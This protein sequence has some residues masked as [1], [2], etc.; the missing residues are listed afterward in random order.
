[1]GVVTGFGLALA[2][3]ATVTDPD[4]FGENNLTVSGPDAS[5]FEVDHNG[6]YVKAGTT[7]S[8]TH[9]EYEVSVQVT[10]P[11]F[12]STPNATSAP[13]KLTVTPTSI[14]RG[15]TARLAACAI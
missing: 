14:K 9:G 6:L 3:V 8:A 4:G 7:L 12:G 15:A 13:Y 1:M 11:A 10:D 5:H 2:V